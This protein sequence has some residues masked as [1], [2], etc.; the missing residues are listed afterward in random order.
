MVMLTEK[1]STRLARIKPIVQQYDF[2]EID[3]I[4]MLEY[5]HN[6]CRK[7]CKK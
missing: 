5:K 2:H 7:D 1:H 6:V 3:C 4:M